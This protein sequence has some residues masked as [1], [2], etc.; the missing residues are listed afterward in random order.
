MQSRKYEVVRTT[1]DTDEMLGQ[2]SARNIVHTWKEDF[3]D[4]STGEVIGVDRTQILFQKGTLLDAE[5]ISSLNFYIQSGWVD[6]VTITNQKRMA[7]YSEVKTPRPFKITA[8]IGTQNKHFILMATGI[9]EAMDA[10]TDW[11]EQK[12]A[13]NFYITGAKELQRFII[14]TDNLRK[15]EALESEEA[16]AKDDEE[17]SKARYYKIE[18]RVDWIDAGGEKTNS[19]LYDFMIQTK[20][21]DTAKVVITSWINAQLRKLRMKAEEEGEEP[22]VTSAEVSITSASPF[23]VEGILDRDFCHDYYAIDS[24]SVEA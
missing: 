21:V 9:R 12:F 7:T 14:L 5:T 3:L 2:Y 8:R 15:A 4:D 23:N 17:R 20:D 1:A 22:G 18:S 13:E 6:T 19:E 24:I 16:K 11:I 10:V